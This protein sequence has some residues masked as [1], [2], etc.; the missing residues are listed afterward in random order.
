MISSVL[1]NQFVKSMATLHAFIMFFM[2]RKVGQ[3]A[4]EENFFSENSIFMN[5]SESFM[6]E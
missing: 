1:E 5:E 6:I 3:S 2:S 4:K